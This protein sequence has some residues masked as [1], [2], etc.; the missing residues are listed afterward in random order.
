MTQE[1]GPGDF[2]FDHPDWYKYAIPLIGTLG[3]PA[4][5]IA[6]PTGTQLFSPVSGTVRV[7]GPEQGYRLGPNMDIY[8]PQTG[9]LMIELDN[10]HRLWLGHMAAIHVSVGDRINAGQY[11]GLSGYA[12][13]GDHL[14]LEYQIPSHKWGGDFEAVDPRQ[15]LMG[16]FG[17]GFSGN[18]VGAGI[19]RPYTFDDLMRAGA[20]G[21]TIFGG[22][23]INSGSTWNS[24]MQRAMNGLIPRVE[25]NTMKS[26][27]GTVNTGAEGYRGYAPRNTYSALGGY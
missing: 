25:G 20:R 13:T 6:M 18:Q 11:V 24:W 5:D 16:V 3:H 23:T 2:A 17:G 10:G 9:G 26:A 27:G 14:H 8:T 15:A 22:M 19:N 1:F 4:L 7:A 21:D 12:G